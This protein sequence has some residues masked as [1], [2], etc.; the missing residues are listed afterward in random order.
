MSDN[1]GRRGSGSQPWPDGFGQRRQVARKLNYKWNASELTFDVGEHVIDHLDNYGVVLEI[2]DGEVL[3]QFDREALPRRALPSLGLRIDARR[4]QLV[5]MIR[6]ELS[7]RRIGPDDDKFVETLRRETDAG[8]LTHK[9]ALMW[10]DWLRALPA[11]LD[12]ERDGCRDRD[13]RH[14]GGTVRC[15]TWFADGCDDCRI[16]FDG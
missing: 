4:E 3:V 10:L 7:R 13:P 9:D 11:R 5:A 15:I 1:S 16:H 12:D 8:A 6:D 14:D 2:A